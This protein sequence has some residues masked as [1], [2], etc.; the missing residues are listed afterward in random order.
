MQCTVVCVGFVQPS[1]GSKERLTFQ[2]S[3]P[4]LQAVSTLV[5]PGR[6][7]PPSYAEA[8]AR[9]T[10]RRASDV[11]GACMRNPP[12]Y[13]VMSIA[14]DNATAG[15]HSS[16]SILDDTSPMYST[17]AVD[18]PSL[19]RRCQSE[20]FVGP[21]H[22]ANVNS[23]AGH[24]CGVTSPL[25]FMEGQSMN[26]SAFRQV[27]P[28]SHNTPAVICSPRLDCVPVTSS[29]CLAQ[30]EDMASST[31]LLSPLTLLSSFTDDNEEGTS[32]DCAGNTSSLSSVAD[33]IPPWGVD[34]HW[35]F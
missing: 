22:R 10:E 35:R 26:G 20:R 28:S 21:L 24:T 7:P 12:F 34:G 9:M 23:F 25:T 6:A 18:G 2:T 15:I 17:T 8:V 3:T 13:P 14:N 16:D 11:C 32:Q 27:P 29:D 4:S 5:P 19:S 1:C 31:D 30:P 33:D